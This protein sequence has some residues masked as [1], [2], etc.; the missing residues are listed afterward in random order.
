MSTLAPNGRSSAEKRAELKRLLR[1]KL[2]REVTEHPLSHG[3]RGLWFLHELAPEV[4]AYS[5]YLALRIRSEIDSAALTTALQTLVDRHPI[6]RTTFGVDAKGQ[7]VQRVRGAATVH[8][9]EVDGSTFEEDDIQQWCAD[10][11]KRPFD[12]RRGPVFRAGVLHVSPRDHL[13]VLAGH[14]IIL[15]QRSL[16]VLIDELVAAYA[17]LALEPPRVRYVDHVEKQLAALAGPEGERL[18]AYWTRELEGDRSPLALPCDRVRPPLMSF[19]GGA[20]PFR[21][22]DE[23]G[24][25]LRAIAADAGT[26]LY[27]VLLA[28]F[29]AFLHRISGNREVVVASPTY[30]RDSDELEGV[31]GYFVNPVPLRADFS[32]EPTF[33]ALLAQVGQTVLGALEHQNYPFPLIVERLGIP[34]DPSRQPLCDVS[35]SSWTV[36]ARGGQAVDTRT[37][38][39]GILSPGNTGL[40]FKIGPLEAEW[41]RVCEKVAHFDLDLGVADAGDSVSMQLQYNADLFD[42]ATVERMAGH[43]TTLLEG[44]ASGGV[45]CPVHA[46]P[47]LTA[48]ERERMLVTWNATERPYDAP[49]RLHVLIEAQVERTPD[50]IAVVFERE[51]LTYREL[52]RAANRM[53]RRLRG[54]GIGPGSHVAVHLARSLDLVIA[55]VGILKAG[56]A[57]VPLDPSY[58]AARLQYIL[59]DSSAKVVVTSTE[60]S[61]WLPAEGALRLEVDRDRE[62]IDGESDA[63]VDGGAG[64]MDP[65]YVMYTSGSTGRPKGV[66]V[67]HRAICNRLLWMQDELALSSDDAVL[68]KTPFGFD[69]SVWEFFWPLL[70]GARLVVARPGVHLDPRALVATIVEH[71][72]TTIHFVPS[73]LALFVEEPSVAS[74]RSL[75][76]V[77][78]SGEALGYALW[79]RFAARVNAP[80]FNLYGPTEAAVDVTCWRCADDPAGTIPIGRPIANIQLYILDAHWQPVPV[81]V[82]GELYIAGVGLATGY[83]GQ[84]ALTEERFL[85]CPFS[86]SGGRM[87]RTGDVARY[88]PDGAIEYLGRVDDQVK[89]NGVR[90][91]LGDVE[92]AIAAERG[93]RECTVV[94]RRLS[95]GGYAL[96]AFVVPEA[97][98]ALSA[99]DLRLALRRVLPEAMV[100]RSI[101]FVDA[102]PISANGKADRA[103]LLRLGKLE[104]DRAAYEAPSTP[105]QATLAAAFS[106][107]LGVP[108]VS[109]HDDFFA[110]GGDSIRSLQLV[111]VLDKRGIV[112]RLQALYQH[113]T[114]VALASHVGAGAFALPTNL[115][116]FSLLSTR[117]G[118]EDLE[119]AYPATL[120][121]QGMVY[122]NQLERGSSTYHDIF[123]YRF[124]GHL[125]PERLHDAFAALTR[126]HPALRSSF[127][128]AVDGEPLQRVHADV[129]PVFEVIDVRHLDAA[130]QE[131]AVRELV[132]LERRRGFDAQ[133]AP[134]LRGFVH[135]CGADSFQ[136]TLSFHHAILDGWS[137]SR[138]V[139]ELL[140]EHAALVSGRPLSQAPAPSAALASALE[141]DALRSDTSGMFFRD[142]LQGAPFTAL[143]RLPIPEAPLT[144]ANA[145]N[146][147]AE[148]GVVERELGPSLSAAV[149]ALARDLRVSGKSVL[150]AAH[151]FVLGIVS[152]TDDVVTGLVTHS[153]PEVDGADRILGLFV[154]ALPLRM[155][156][157]DQS[158][159]ALVRAVDGAERELIAHRAFPVAEVQRLLGGRAL[160]EVAFNYVNYHTAASLSAS[161]GV[162]LVDV[163]IFERTSFALTVTA[164]RRPGSGEIALRLAYDR[165]DL[166]R[167]RI[168]AMAGYYVEALRAMTEDPTASCDHA[169]VLGATE[170]AAR[171]EWNDTRV[172]FAVESID[173]LFAAQVART[174][175]EVAVIFGDE[176]I[177]YAELDRRSNELAGRLVAAGYG[178]GKLV[179]LCLT[180]SVDMVASVIAVLKA[181]SAYVPLDPSYPQA[182]MASILRTARPCAILVQDSTRACVP[183]EAAVCPMV[184][185][186][187]LP[188]PRSEARHSESDPSAVAYVLFTSGSTGEPKGI[189][190]PHGALSN[191]IRYQIE[192]SAL[193]RGA[194]TLQFASLSFDVSF[195]EIFATLCDGGTL[196]LIA[197]ADRRDPA[198]LLS[199]LEKHRIAR[200]VLP[201]VALQQ[202]ARAAADGGVYPSALREVLSSGEALEITPEIR[203]LFEAM[204]ECVLRNQYGPTEAHVVTHHTLL[205]AP[206]AWPIL[207]PIGKPICNATTHILDKNGRP[208]PIG[209][210][211]ELYLGGVSLAVG[212]YGSPDLTAERFI[213]HDLPGIGPMRLYRTGDAARYLPDGSIEF[214]GRLD[215]QVK[216]RGYRVELAAVEAA[217]MELPGVA[218]AAARKAADAQGD[219]ILAAYVVP[220]G[221]LET[222]EWTRSLR[223]RLPDYMV[224]AVFVRMQEMPL[225]ASGKLD[226]KR[227]PDPTFDG[228]RPRALTIPPRDAVELQLA[229]IWEELLGVSAVGV[230]DDFFA[231]GGHS[232]TAL[233]LKAKIRNTLGRDIPLAVILEHPTVGALARHIRHAG[234]SPAPFATSSLVPLTRGGDRPP[235]FCVHPIGG[236]AL[237]YV[238]LARRLRETGRPFYAFQAVGLDGSRA[239]LESVEAMASHYVELLCAAQPEGPITLGGWS[240]GGMLAVAMADQLRRMGREISALVLFDTMVPRPGPSI[241]RDRASWTLG[242]SGADP[243]L[244]RVFALDLLTG[245]RGR[246][247]AEDDAFVD[248]CDG[249]LSKLLEVAAARGAVP[250]GTRADDLLPI[251]RVFES[252]VLAGISYRP[253]QDPGRITLLRA[254]SPLPAP[255]KPI[256]ER[257]GSQYLDPTNGWGA[258]YPGQVEVYSVPGDHLTLIQEPNID[259]IVRILD[260]VLDTA[261]CRS[262]AE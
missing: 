118:L 40:V 160:Y 223:A 202:L 75:R 109:I 127:D 1:K 72:V 34:S 253:P 120:L 17:G 61:S 9:E 247:E 236:N 184:T 244:R 207:V 169:V 97:P 119:D 129:A 114:V 110:L 92:A 241:V 201:F 58:P 257:M 3:Q 179:G 18:A 116:P 106:E 49:D 55:L 113:P 43:F 77:I 139:Y 2:E 165:A 115:A 221:E 23:I 8:V 232:L 108:D 28:A 125:E 50:A 87:Y 15:D 167:E 136:L 80:L 246:I 203:R 209:T 36:R 133:E 46:L 220:T 171:V 91:E 230:N 156:L 86:A 103:A 168:E 79:Q 258:L 138:L 148:P 224:P 166:S 4:G 70:T 173:R 240:F 27:A 218:V 101:S 260:H 144:E 261:S 219:A 99:H 96:E 213:T 67:P 14:H 243:M 41:Y 238:A 56:G 255:L 212:Y 94:A 170:L 85:P 158:F 210:V 73:M 174:P 89:V 33:R 88:R 200:L 181:G 254:A 157:A 29:Q 226:R 199:L 83:H 197:E 225:T 189:A 24:S 259:E 78:A 235:F 131:G 187:E 142:K 37:R 214:F 194:R 196:V 234:S 154:N 227:L 25:R 186:D 162:E 204:P 68:Q 215:H 228:P 7:P 217:L 6:L 249:D 176:A 63:P 19:R 32:G 16:N 60:L 149:D 12:L 76:R 239:P 211:G 198:T 251:L 22:R 233:R 57:Y 105:V 178:G 51:Q 183:G 98:G 175:H 52:D 26:T 237:C 95:N 30:G 45:D 107:V 250:E 128:L 134:L 122:H 252:S 192:L 35:Y 153:R 229:S 10:Q 100:P 222:E 151:L 172:P 62:R 21:L 135:L 84:P 11:A 161:A 262:A 216:I 38:A 112:V 242:G 74:I 31:V 152:G 248:A 155:R 65:A 126:R 47:L 164:Y 177:T 145:Q 66:I 90:I 81:G 48:E 193:P 143:P 231:L 146:A 180:R 123:S 102:I 59:E 190:M 5:E 245:F 82:A 147:L 64:P 140:T 13:L 117:R 69:V 20:H 163:R 150:L 256:H 130:R 188:P 182:W 141:L 93:V 191:L 53:A 124:R 42:G 195:Q 54:L 104:S 121:Q 185:L 71:E 205:G 39:T 44:I 206:G 132:E 137:V 111:G 208:A 159:R